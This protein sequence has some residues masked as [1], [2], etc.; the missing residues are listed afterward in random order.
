MKQWKK[1]V[2]LSA[3]AVMVA[4]AIAPTGADLSGSAYAQQLQTEMSAAQEETRTSTVQTV[5][6]ASV[7]ADTYTLSAVRQQSTG[8]RVTA[9]GWI[10]YREDTGSNYSNL[11]IQDGSAGIVIRGQNLPGEPGQEIETTG[12]LSEYRKLLQIE[13]AAADTYIRVQ[14]PQSVSAHPITAAD[15]TADNPYE[16]QL[17]RIQQVTVTGKSSN[18]YTLQDSSGSF[19]VYSKNPWLTVGQSYDSITGVVSQYND[20]IQLIPRSIEDI[21][22]GTP[23]VVEAPVK[24]AIHDIQGASQRSPYEGQEVR[25]VEGIVTMV[26]GKTIFYM[27]TE[28]ALADQDERTSEAIMV[29]K[30]AHGMKVGDRVSVDGTV[31]EYKETG[32]SDAS[33]LT[34]T[35]IAA[36]AI[37][38]LAENQ[39]LPQPVVIGKGGRTIPGQIASPQG[40]VSFDPSSYSI[41]LY[42]SLEGMR[43]QLNNASIIGPYTYE[44]PVTVDRE[45]S[46]SVTP[47]GGLVI[48]NNQ[49][50]P[51]RLLI[52]EKPK[53]PVK[54]GD[55]FD[56]P[57]YGIMSYSYSNFKVLPEN[58]LPPIIS[59]GLKR[60]VSTLYNGTEQLTIASFNVENFWDDPANQKKTER[61]ARNVT[62]NLH[63]PDIIGLMEVQD[64]NGEKDDGTA[65][66]SASFAA[67][68]R[69][70]QEAGGPEYRYTSI[71]PQNNEDG[72]APGGNIR[73]GF[74]YNPARVTLA[75]APGGAGD[76]VTAVTYG[77][78]GLTHNPGRI[79]PGNEAFAHSRKSLAAQFVFNG[80]QV[81]VVANHFNSKGGDQALYGAAQPPQRIS[82]V[83]RAKQATLLNSFVKNTL[84]QNSNANIVLVGDFNDYQFSNTLQIL[85]GS[86]L[87]NM[88]DTLP[89][90]ERYSYVYEGNSQTLD[91]ILMT[92]GLAS[93]AQLDIVHLNADFMEADGR[94]S[95]HD[96]LL[97]RIDFSRHSDKKDDKNHSGRIPGNG[98][99]SNGSSGT[100]GGSTAPAAPI[101]PAPVSMN[102]LPTAEASSTDG[103]V[104]SWSMTP[105]MSQET[106]SGTVAGSVLNASST[107]AMLAQAGEASTL[108]IRI[109]PAQTADRYRLEWQPEA[110][111]ALTAQNNIK[112]IAIATPVGTYEIPVSW[113]QSSGT[114]QERLVLEISAASAAMQQARNNGYSA[115][116]AVEY[117][118]YTLDGNNAKQPVQQMD[119]YIQRS[120][121][122]DGLVSTDRIAVVRI[123]TGSD[124]AVTYIP[125]PFTVQN[126]AV[127]LFSRSN[128]TYAV[129]DSAIQLKDLAGHWAQTDIQQLADQ[130]IVTGTAQGA[131]RPN[132]SITRA[133][134]SALLVRT[135]GL[136]PI[137]NS[138]TTFNDVNSSAWYADSVG[139]AAAAGLIQGDAKGQFRPNATITREEMA[140]LLERALSYSG[141][142]VAENINN[143]PTDRNQAAQWA[144]PA[145][146]RLSASGLISGNAAGQFQPKKK[147]TRAES[148]AILSRLLDQLT[149]SAN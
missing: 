145:I 133:E 35:E 2:S 75:D 12:K 111:Q 105:A 108:R 37:T 18:N 65:D 14:A 149:G 63:T 126:G 78:Q 134:M 89:E 9:R 53:Q 94:V 62:E 113:L 135:L 30:S 83:Q 119:R 28:D 112:Q 5:P 132:A 19:T 6:S 85:K 61:I 66:A 74:L 57:L 103:T 147:L 123:E 87:T 46:R 40:L 91:H 43:V 124:G 148:A 88:V 55:R 31:K 21:A 98:S 7:S 79:E 86:E 92:T 84:A 3:A 60:E 67:L 20:S 33:D 142:T 116:A 13:A 107:A 138:S 102:T 59:G 96:P 38:R 51:N 4:S 29:Y 16:G 45:E 77:P 26:K 44:I 114:G 141:M 11:Y 54:T 109:Q 68:I 144:R 23:P 90:N 99:G 41:D 130:R 131:F 115:R 82:E 73:V 34:T 146:D 129:I 15:L 110:R 70:I 47:A 140:V 71:A 97:T 139:T 121:Q 137:D 118:L 80:Q 10:T 106:G 58:G 64:N 93:R 27:Q 95:D 143:R 42:E 32:Y 120:M 17:V 127:T 22:K 122:V 24:L 72:G 81:I 49:F 48:A 8:S 136:T 39:S 117:S 128:S 52:G 101:S 100:G 50:N 76:S 69:E 56:G 125:V 25:E 1:K 36:S 104:S